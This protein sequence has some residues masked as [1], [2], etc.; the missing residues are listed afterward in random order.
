METRSHLWI[1]LKDSARYGIKN[2]KKIG[3]AQEQ[4]SVIKMFILCV[5]G[6]I[7]K[8]VSEL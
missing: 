3:I 2:F 6:F 7:A 8:Y 4:I 5:A 1:A